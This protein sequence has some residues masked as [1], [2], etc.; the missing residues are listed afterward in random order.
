MGLELGRDGLPR[1]A[2]GLIS[3]NTAGMCMARTMVMPWRAVASAPARKVS[4][5][6]G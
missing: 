6:Q 4:K 2:V 1:H 5:T 3:W